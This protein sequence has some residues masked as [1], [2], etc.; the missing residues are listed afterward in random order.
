MVK[1]LLPILICLL[2]AEAGQAGFDRTPLKIFAFGNIYTLPLYNGKW[3]SLW[4]AQHYDCIINIGDSKQSMDT[5]YLTAKDS[6]KTMWIGP[7]QSSQEIPVIAVLPYTSPYAARLLDTARNHYYIYAKWY[8]DSIGVSD[9]SLVVHISDTHISITQQTG[10]NRDFSL[11]GLNY[12]ETRFSYQNWYNTD[13]DTFTYP[14]GCLWLANGKNTNTRKAYAYSYKR[15]FIEDS[16]KATIGGTPSGTWHYNA[17]YMDNQYRDAG[18]LGSY[19][20]I[21]STAGGLTTQMDW[22]EQTAIQTDSQMYYYDNSTLKIDSSIRQVLDSVCTAKSWPPIYGF[23]NIVKNNPAH[24]GAVV[25]SGAVNAVSLEN[26]IDYAKGAITWRNWLAMAD[27]MRAH[28][29]VQIAW[30]IPYDILCDTSATNWRYDSSRIAYYHFAFYLSVM[31]T[32]SWFGAIRWNDTT[33]WR[34]IFEIDPQKAG[35][36]ATIIDS[37]GTGGGAYALKQYIIRRYFTLG[38]SDTTW[39]FYR[40]PNASTDNFTTDFVTVPL[41][42]NLYYINVNGDTAASYSSSISLRPYE[43]WIGTNN[44]EGGPSSPTIQLSSSSFSFSG[45]VGGSNPANQTIGV[46][47]IGGGTMPWTLVVDGAW[48]TALPASGT[49]P[50]TVTLSISTTGLTAGTYIGHVVIYATGA[51]N[52]PQAAT[53]TLTMTNPVTPTT[54]PSNLKNVHVKGGHLK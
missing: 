26:P 12:S 38:A 8:M 5:I 13:A 19:Y 44:G 35:P 3:N 15:T 30:A 25:S 28:P 49:A 45:I 1:R 32:N 40:T 46:N 14:N 9:E 2:L 7:Y 41:G 10:G 4:M 31:D 48:L 52:T 17:F 54:K 50:S 11:V 47:N 33:K 22:I 34:D 29:E 6:G 27:T 51:T 16:A 23:A 42:R 43:A 20:T 18:R 24:L 21:V 39:V 36:K 37:V 53:V